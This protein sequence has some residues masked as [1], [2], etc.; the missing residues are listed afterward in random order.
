MARTPQVSDHA[1]LRY[2][3][4]KY[5]LDTD[6]IRK[7]ILTP[8]ALAAIKRG[9]TSFSEDNIKFLVQDGVVL[10]SLHGKKAMNK[11]RVR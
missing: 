3:E 9:A 10:T 6:A 5:N 11:R 7:E 1:V 2:L 4:R 8:Q